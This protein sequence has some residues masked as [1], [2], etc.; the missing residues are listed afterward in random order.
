M[1][2]GRQDSNLGMPVPKTSALPLGYAPLGKAQE[3]IAHRLSDE[4]S[5][6][7]LCAACNDPFD[8]FRGNSLCAPQP[9][10]QSSHGEQEFPLY[11]VLHSLIMSA[12]I[13]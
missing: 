7:K 9:H 2:L 1:W 13:F 11:S 8:N 6:A 3:Q 5:L 10:H 12:Q 4:R